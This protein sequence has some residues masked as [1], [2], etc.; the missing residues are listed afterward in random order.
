MSTTK[1]TLTLSLTAGTKAKL[2]EIARDH[3]CFWGKSPSPSALVTAIANKEIATGDPFYLNDECIL[4][5][6][7]AV[8]VLIDNGDVIEAETIVRLIL[9]KSKLEPTL[10]QELLKL[11]NTHLDKWRLVVNDYI[12]KKQPFKIFY[13]NS[14]GQ[15]LIFNVYFAQEN[16]HERRFYLNIWCEET[17]DVSEDNKKY[18]PELIHNRC[19]R[20]D[21]IQGIMPISG[22][23]RSSLDYIQVQIQLTGWMV[24][25]Y[26]QREKDSDDKTNNGVRSITRKVYNPFWLM[27]EIKG[28][29]QNCTIIKP[30]GLR[31]YFK[32]EIIKMIQL[33]DQ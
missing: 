23:W 30:D 31:N 18:F 14:Q 27:R 21:R 26:K 29:G 3:G 25:A 7:Q 15:E 24:K 33:Y 17:D 8:K 5:L 19:L 9:D 2:E 1:E 20:F 32:Q 12:E 28:Y 22:E 10:R 13:I 4:A 16:F 6:T 11:V